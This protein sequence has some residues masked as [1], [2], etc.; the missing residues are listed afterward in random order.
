[1]QRSICVSIMAVTCVHPVEHIH[2][3]GAFRKGKF[4]RVRT[5]LQRNHVHVNTGHIA[6]TSENEY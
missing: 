2:I 1:M 6:C 5:R 4:N 3:R